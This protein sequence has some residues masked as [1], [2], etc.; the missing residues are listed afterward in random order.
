MIIGSFYPLDKIDSFNPLNPFAVAKHSLARN[1][2][3]ALGLY[4]DS[5]E[6]YFFV[7]PGMEKS[8]ETSISN[9]WDID[10]ECKNVQISS[11]F[12]FLDILEKPNFGILHDLG[13]LEVSELA[14]IRSKF[15]R[16][17]F[18]ITMVIWPAQLQSL[19][20]HMALPSPPNFCSYDSLICMN[21]ALKDTIERLFDDLQCAIPANTRVNRPL[22]QV[23]HIPMGIDT[24]I[25]C[26]REKNDV[27]HQLQLPVN[28]KIILSFC[29]LSVYDNMD[30]V[31]LIRAFQQ[32]TERVSDVTLVI[33]GSDKPYEYS[34]QLRDFLSGV[35]AKD[36]I[37]LW[38]DVNNSAMP[39]LYSA[40]DIFVSPSDTVQQFTCSTLIEAM[41]SGLAIVASDWNGYR[42]ILHHGEVGF[43]I[44]TFCAECYS[45]IKRY[46][47]ILPNYLKQM[48]IAQSVAVDVEEMVHYLLLLLENDA[49]RN[50]MGNLARRHAIE[51][52]SLPVIIEQYEELWMDLKHK[53]QGDCQP[54]SND[55]F[56]L[57]E[58]MEIPRLH[59][60]FKVDNDTM[61]RRT[62]Y[63]EEVL[64]TS[65]LS[66]YEEMKGLLYYPIMFEILNIAHDWL[67]VDAIINHLVTLSEDDYSTIEQ[68]VLYQIMWLV[69]QGF[70]RIKKYSET[71]MANDDSRT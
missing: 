1:F 3:R 69:K 60:S 20:F 41:S 59:A 53:A 66:S 22:P 47:P 42:D 23:V 34:K 7:F 65:H 62:N 24:D 33:A 48:Y 18:P 67:S 29:K 11:L 16:Q 30:F 27:R 35:Q 55:N 5:N 50:K 51:K 12:N 44:S 61:V 57:L 14:Y 39:L 43:K 32:V 56:L 28:G 21:I 4:S 46:F 2:I 49:L 17:P 31:P 15:R 25:F 6:Y 13:G 58:Q 8:I 36:K 52:Y 68:E 54:P 9:L 64:K 70:I 26:P 10:S 63:G 19:A 38:E 71:L 45:N 37:V 40:A